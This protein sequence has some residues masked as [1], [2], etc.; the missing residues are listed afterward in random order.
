MQRKPQ[1]E[2]R[3][4]EDFT[5]WMLSKEP[6]H[7]AEVIDRGDVL[8]IRVKGPKGGEYEVEKVSPPSLKLPLT[9]HIPA[10]LTP[11]KGPSPVQLTLQPKAKAQFKAWIEKPTS[12][13]L[14]IHPYVHAETPEDLITPEAEVQLPRLEGASA[15]VKIPELEPLN[16]PVEEG[17][18]AVPSHGLITTREVTTREVLEAHHLRGVSLFELVLED[19]SIRRLVGGSGGIVEEPIFIVARKSPAEILWYPIWVVCK[20]IYREARGEYPEPIDLSGASEDEAHRRLERLEHRGGGSGKILVLEQE[21]LE[22]LEGVLKR[23]FREAFSRGLGFIIVTA[24]DVESASKKIRDLC[25]PYSPRMV[26]LNL[27]DEDAREFAIR[28]GK[29]LQAIFGLPAESFEGSLN[30]ENVAAGDLIMS[31]A[32]RAYRDF[33]EEMLQSPYIA[34]VERDVSPKESEDHVALKVLSVKHLVEEGVKLETITCNRSFPNRVIADLYVEDRGLAI[35]AETLFGTGPAP[36]LKIFN[37]VR[38]YKGVEEI[39]EIWVVVHNWAAALHLGDLYHAEQLLRKE[40]RKEVRIFVPSLK[41]RA[42]KPLDEI[43]A[44]LLRSRRESR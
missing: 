23:R 5:E 8:L 13:G 21:H 11:L 12:I 44:H 16:L 7:E 43:V 4:V 1:Y 40:L 32:D 28:L 14:P 20:E 29:A 41:E 3:Y 10:T 35:E 27:S 26:E 37:S 19:S 34:N 9:G 18:K 42:L 39:K 36:I 38:K 6:D 24:E 17:V 15:H 2:L 31:R 25:R 22:N 30:M 33:V